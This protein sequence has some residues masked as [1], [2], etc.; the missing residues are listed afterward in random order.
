MGCNRLKAGYQLSSYLFNIKQII[1]TRAMC[2]NPE[3]DTAFIN[4]IGR[5]IKFEIK[6]DTLVLQL[7]NN[8]GLMYFERK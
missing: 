6:V 5:V 4:D 2:E 3:L 1:T 8:V 7:D